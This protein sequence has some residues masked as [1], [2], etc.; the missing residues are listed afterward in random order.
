MSKYDSFWKYIQKRTE[1]SFKLT[2]DEIGEIAGVP[3]D[4]SFLNYKNELMSY[5]WVGK[6]SII[7]L[8]IMQHKWRQFN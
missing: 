3:I 8:I 7:N 2:F 6:I 1:Q 5:G 4:H